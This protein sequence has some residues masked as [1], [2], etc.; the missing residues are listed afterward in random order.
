M[1]KWC[2]K[3]FGINQQDDNDDEDGMEVEGEGLKVK[4]KCCI[5]QKEFVEPIACPEK[6]KKCIFEK[7]AILDHVNVRVQ[8]S[9]Q[10]KCPMPGCPAIFTNTKEF[11][12]SAVMTN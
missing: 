6:C 7:L 3:A 8:Q 1:G 11:D 9:G 2:E 10:C 4:N 12:T 5:T